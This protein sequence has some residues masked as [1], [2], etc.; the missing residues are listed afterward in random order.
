[1]S[2]LDITGSC[3]HVFSHVGPGQSGDPGDLV[4]VKYGDLECDGYVRDGPNIGTQGREFFLE[5]P[6]KT[7]VGHVG[8]MLTQ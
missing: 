5:R 3:R 6:N 8:R 2:E 7:R 1:M 4:K